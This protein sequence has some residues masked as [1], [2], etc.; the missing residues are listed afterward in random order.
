M[1]VNKGIH[2]LTAL[3]IKVLA[4]WFFSEFSPSVLLMATLS[5]CVP[6]VCLDA[7]T[8]SSCLLIRA[9][10]ILEKDLS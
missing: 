6:M 2:V 8:P 10:V 3:K 9:H 7:V 4:V 1:G 5:S